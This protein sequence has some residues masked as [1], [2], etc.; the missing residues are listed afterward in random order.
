MNALLR[1]DEV[2]E[3]LAVSRRTIYR[4]A[5]AGEIAS[6]PLGANL[7][8]KPEDIAAFIESRRRAVGAKTDPLRS[9]GRALTASPTRK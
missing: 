5:R 6:V 7:R 1:P 9:G 2:A 3:M 4:L 8:F